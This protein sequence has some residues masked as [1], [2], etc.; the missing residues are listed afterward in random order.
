MRKEITKDV[1]E[2]VVNILNNIIETEETEA[3]KVWT[4]EGK[5]FDKNDGYDAERVKVM[6]RLAPFVD[7]LSNEVQR[8]FDGE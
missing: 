7:E 8:I 3:F 1:L 4:E 2:E 6:E 5:V